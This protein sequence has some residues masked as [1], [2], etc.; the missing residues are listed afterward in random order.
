MKRL[1]Y[2]GLIAAYALTA[3]A[4]GCDKGDSKVEVRSH[5]I[6]ATHDPYCRIEVKE[7]E[8]AGE[9]VRF[10]VELLDPT[11]E[12]SAV[13]C[14]GEN[15][16]ALPGDGPVFGYEFIMPDKD[17]ALAAATRPAQTISYPIHVAQSELFEVEAPEQARSGESV[18]VKVTV[19]DITYKV[20]SVHFNDQPCT[21]ISNVGAEFLYRFEMPDEEVTLTVQLTEDYHPITPVQGEHSTLAILNCHYNYGTPEHIIQATALEPVYYTVEAEIG[22]DLSHYALTQSGTHIT[23]SLG[24]YPDYGACWMVEMPDE[25]LSV[26]SQATEKTTYAGRDFLGRYSGYQIDRSPSRVTSSSAASLSM[27]LEA[28]TVFRVAS[29]D[30]HAFDFDG[31]YAFDESAQRF[32]F[33]TDYCKKTYGVSGNVVDECALVWVM[34]AVKGLSAPTYLYFTGKTDFGYTCASDLTASKYLLELTRGAEKTYYFVDTA[35]WSVKRAEVQFDDGVSIASPCS[36]LVSVEGSPLYRYTLQADQIPHF[37]PKGREAGTYTCRDGS[38]PELILDGFGKGSI[39]AAEGTYTVDQGIVL[40]T[41]GNQTTTYLINSDNYTY[42][43]AESD[44]DWNGPSH[45]FAES[46]FAFSSEFSPTWA[47]GHVRILMDRDWS[48]D[49][50]G[51]AHITLS[52][53]DRFG[54]QTNIVEDA[55]PYVYDASKGTLV[56]SRI[57]QGIVEGDS[58]RQGRADIAFTVSTDKQSL[59]CTSE[60]VYS[61][62]TPEKYIYTKDLVLP[63]ATGQ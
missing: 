18:A 52:V 28:N 57:L 32:D 58:F 25:P 4:T 51:Y 3:S 53:P 24:N 50:P 2:I 59:T 13:T 7:R 37:Q 27:T 5:P 56:V 15:C 40:F 30:S 16:P 60:Y 23:P 33:L 49:K 62:G 43:K 21:Y 48:G 61:M 46:N 35:I 19:S 39:G 9:K 34:D 8:T 29:T 12:L 44:D 1:K 63:A 26:V 22:Y 36:A 55:G 17:V 20:G 14:N 41:T 38:G 31:C 54:R 45:Y 10:T 6:T 42:T 47:T 11:R